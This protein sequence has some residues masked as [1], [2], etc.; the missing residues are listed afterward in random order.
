MPSINAVNATNH[1]TDLAERQK[2]TNSLNNLSLSGKLEDSDNEFHEKSWGMVL[3]YGLSQLQFSDI[4]EEKRFLNYGN[5]FTGGVSYEIP[6]NAFNG[7]FSFYNEIVF[8]RYNAERTF[9]SKDT[10]EGVFSNVTKHYEFTPNMLNTN[11][12]IRYNFT[13]ETDFRYFIGIGFYQ[14]LIL[15]AKNDL[16]QT[17]STNSGEKIIKDDAIPN[18]SKYG[19]MLLLSTGFTYRNFGLELKIDPGRNLSN[20]FEY[21]AFAP[22]FSLNLN[23]RFYKN[24]E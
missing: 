4:Y 14:S 19:I 8:Q 7:K 1:K 18:L 3:G 23:I 6:I 11:H 10:V 20:K 2:K 12:F 15:S 16:T 22:T 21:Q 5:F 9:I 13:G 24:M 17:V